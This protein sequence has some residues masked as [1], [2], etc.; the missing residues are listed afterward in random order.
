[1]SSIVEQVARLAGWQRSR[2][3]W[4]RVEWGGDRWSVIVEWQGMSEIADPAAGLDQPDPEGVA[5]RAWV[6]PG[7]LT[8]ARPNGASIEAELAELAESG[9]L[10]D[11][12]VDRIEDPTDLRVRWRAQAWI[13]CTGRVLLVDGPAVGQEMIAAQADVAL[14]RW[15][16]RQAQ[17]AESVA[18]SA[19]LAGGIGATL[20]HRGM[21]ISRARIYQIRDGRR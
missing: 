7:P 3:D 21:G 14:A 19:A 5:H 1:M 16:L 8:M 18:T 9:L 10:G 11:M 12:T 13:G 6:K 17:A 4:V 2:V 15:R 20:A